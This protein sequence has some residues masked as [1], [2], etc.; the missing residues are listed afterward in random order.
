MFHQL[1]DLGWVYLDLRCSTILLGC[2]A[3][4]VQ[5]SSA[6][7]GRP[8]KCLDQSEPNKGPRADGTPCSFDSLISFHLFRH[9]NQLSLSGPSPGGG[10]LQ[11]EHALQVERHPH[12][13]AAQP[14]RGRPRRRR[15]RGTP[16]Q[17]RSRSGQPDGDAQPGT[18]R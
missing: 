15:R 18:D 9:Y 7:W 1:V 10:R 16:C 14:A 6:E 12:P 5:V 17:P 4:S 11:P 8:W 13:G 3:E 2:S